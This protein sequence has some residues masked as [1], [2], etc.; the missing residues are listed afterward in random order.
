MDYF[1]KFLTP[2]M[3]SLT[4]SYAV[5][6]LIC[7][8]LKEI[9]RPVTPE[10][11][12]E[13]ALSDGILNYFYYTEAMNS[14]LEAKTIEIK[15]VDG[16]DYY[17]LT[18]MGRAGAESFKT[19]VPKS[20]RDKILAAGLKFFAKLKIEHDVKCEITKLDK[21]YSVSCVC[22]DNDV[23]LMDMKLFAP[24]EEQAKLIREKIMQ[25]PTEFYGKVLNYA[26]ENEQYVPE[27]N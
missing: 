25:N 23:V 9:D 8:F 11:L 15:N 24:D 19:I 22:N 20:F 18:E 13:I 12:T 5:K 21:G 1:E 16:V 27:I 2:N 26:L 10:Q 6:I 4:D 17:Y 14:M 3:L 7:Y